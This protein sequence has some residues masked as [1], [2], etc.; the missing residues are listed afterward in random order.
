MSKKEL[1]KQI[2]EKNKE[3]E[4]LRTLL[5]F[6]IQI[7]RF[8]YNPESAHY[9]SC[10]AMEETVNRM[11]MDGKA[12]HCTFNNNF[13]LRYFLENLYREGYRKVLKREVEE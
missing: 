5:N 10:I 6:G 12:Y 13:Y 3:I 1:I 4:Y 8:D 9:E 11:I 2:D 7:E